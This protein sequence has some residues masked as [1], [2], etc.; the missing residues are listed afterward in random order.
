MVDLNVGDDVRIRQLLHSVAGDLRISVN[1]I[2]DIYRD[3]HRNILFYALK[4]QEKLRASQVSIVEII[5][6]VKGQEINEKRT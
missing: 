3:S 5:E 6:I 2:D 4:I 1:D